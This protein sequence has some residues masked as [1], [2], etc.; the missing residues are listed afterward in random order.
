MTI[1][2]IIAR[3]DELKP[4]AFTSEQKTAWIAALEGRIAADVFLMDIS[5]IRQLCYKHPEDEEKIPLVEFPHDD[6][7]VLW[8]CAQIDAANEEYTGYQNAL[9][10]YNDAFGNFVR[11]FASV[12]EPAQVGC[13]VQR[14]CGVPTYYISAYGLAIK[15]GFDGTLDEWLASLTAYGVAVS[16]GYKGSVDEWLASLKGEKGDV[17]DISNVD[18]SLDAVSTRPVQNKVIVAGMGRIEQ[19][20]DVERA[21][22][23]ELTKLGDGSTTGD[24]ELTDARVAFNGYTYPNAGEAVR[25]QTSRMNDL[26]EE[27]SRVNGVVKTDLEF[28][29]WNVNYK[30]GWTYSWSNRRIRTKEGVTIPLDVGDV[31]SLTDY[32][33]HKFYISCRRA[34]GGGYLDGGTWKTAD[35]EVTTSGDY[36][37]QIATIDGTAVES[38]L[39]ADSL[40]RIHRKNCLLQ[41]QTEQTI[42]ADDLEVGGFTNGELVEEPQRLRTKGYIQL[43]KGDSVSAPW[44]LAHGTNINIGVAEYDPVT[45]KFLTGSTSWVKTYY[46]A[47]NDCLAKIVWQTPDKSFAVATQIG[48]KIA[49]GNTTDINYTRALAYAAA[50]DVF[51][52]ETIRSVAH[53]GVIGSAPECTGAAI[54]AARRKHFQWVENDLDFT[55]DGELVMWHD[56]TLAKLG[57]LH[58]SNG[59][60]LYQS[61]TADYWYDSENGVVYSVVDG[62]YVASDVDVS[63]LTQASATTA[64]VQTLKL[65]TLKRLDFGSWF[66]SD[67]AGEQILTFAEFVLLCKQLGLGMVVDVKTGVTSEHITTAVNIVK[68]YG[69]LKFA[70]WQSYYDDVRA[71]D[72]SACL[73]YAST[74]TEAKIAEYSKY[75]ESGEFQFVP[76]STTLNETNAALARNAGFTLECWYVGNKTKAQI[77]AEVE[78]VSALGITGITLDNYRVQDLFREKHLC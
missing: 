38:V 27:S 53:R 46:V 19:K 1:K 10:R 26:L 9:I 17:G 3:V 51:M 70:Q 23:N 63:T 69:M 45:L 47:Q 37:L 31:I 30:T 61:D 15:Q 32:S 72:P 76:E 34:D 4:N 56:T 13:G 28:G 14:R 49:K 22:I 67:F 73:R 48:T 65:A 21:R 77:F 59:Y 66:S 16:Q 50:D 29:A 55:A 41:F 58:D 35:F 75:L 24:A 57:T 40:L 71:V 20:I 54:I 33:N 36:T 78:R 42:T 12:Y 2:E 6:I 52:Q 8:L 68:K 44:S 11:W 60:L 18:E 62:E 43:R 39:K 64:S 7:Y 74:I 5:E 25:G